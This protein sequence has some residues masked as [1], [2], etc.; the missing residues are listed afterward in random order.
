[1]GPCKT[2]MMELLDRKK[3][4]QNNTYSS[5]RHSD[6]YPAREVSATLWLYLVRTSLSFANT[7]GVTTKGVSSSEL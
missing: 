3:V 5:C 2:E 1:M 6:V 4:G 7:E